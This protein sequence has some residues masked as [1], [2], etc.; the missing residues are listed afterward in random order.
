MGFKPRTFISAGQNSTT[1]SFSFLSSNDRWDGWLFN[2][3]WSLL[4]M[5]RLPFSGHDLHTRGWDL[6]MKGQPNPDS[7]PVLP[8]QG[9]NHATKWAN[10][11]GEPC[12]SL[13]MNCSWPRNQTQEPQTRVRTPSAHKNSRTFQGLFLNIPGPK[14]TNWQQI[15]IA[16]TCSELCLGLWLKENKLDKF[17]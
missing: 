14:I 2:L 10:E 5:G 8:C 3:A 15:F 17:C 16:M 13:P 11:S 1:K 6:R 7:N 9:S 4:F 12:W